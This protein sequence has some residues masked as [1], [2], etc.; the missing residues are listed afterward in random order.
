L[1]IDVLT[2]F[3]EMFQSPFEESIFKRA[4]DKNLVRLEIHNF[5]DFSHDKHHAVDDTPYGGGAGMLLKPEPLF[6]AV[7]A[8]MEKDPT[9][10]PV[11]L[12]S[13][14]GRTFNQSVARELA[15]HQRLII[16]CGHYEGFDERVREHLATDEIS[17]GDFVLTGGELAAMVVVDA[18]SRLIPG[19]LGSDDSSESDSHSNGL[20]EHPHYTRPP[21]F[22]GWD[23][24]EVLL[25]GNHARIDRWRRKESLRRTLKRR[26]DMLEKITLSKADRKLID[27]ILDEENPED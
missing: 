1:K 9:P 25:S 12:L 16:I 22:R 26:P 15:N 4:A 3:P 13:P 17:I 8:V 10:A 2:L 18:V 14:Q 5:R 20:L 21:V 19:V 24:P 23:I 7:E 6:E 27:E 11:I